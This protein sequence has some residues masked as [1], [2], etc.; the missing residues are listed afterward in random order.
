[1]PI[2][3][4]TVLQL[5][6]TPNYLN[7]NSILFVMGTQIKKFTTAIIVFGVVLGISLSVDAKAPTNPE[8]SISKSSITFSGEKPVSI[9]L[10]KMPRKAEE[11]EIGGLVYRYYE[12]Y[13]YKSE[14][15]VFVRTDAPIGAVVKAIPDNYQRIIISGR[16]YYYSNGV[17]YMSKGQK[18]FMTTFGPIGGQVSKLPDGSQAIIISGRNYYLYNDIVFRKG[19]S[20]SRKY[21]EVFGYVSE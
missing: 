18:D 17:F 3:N 13:F 10:D 15:E 7:I 8:K 9:T 20:R 6:K 11:I 12:G 1:M 5:G 21:F 4:I 16:I 2:L 19:E 14:G